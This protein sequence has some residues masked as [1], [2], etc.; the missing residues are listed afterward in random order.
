LVV[1]FFFSWLMW[2]NEKKNRGVYT[3]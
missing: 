3:Y 1:T 2:V